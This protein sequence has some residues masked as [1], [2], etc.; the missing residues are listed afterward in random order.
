MPRA[1]RC[2][3]CLQGQESGTDPT[4]SFGYLSLSNSK[5]VN[6]FSIHQNRFLTANCCADLT[7]YRQSNRFA[8]F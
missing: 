4:F 7:N 2:E 8:R 1:G 5:L 3:L 6:E